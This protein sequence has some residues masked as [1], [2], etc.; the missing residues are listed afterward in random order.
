MT[1][2]LV[3]EIKNSY[4]AP[5]KSLH[6]LFALFPP[7]ETAKHP[8]LAISR[9]LVEAQGGR[10]LYATSSLPQAPYTELI[11]SLPAC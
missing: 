11:I 1:Q 7:K 6:E 4:I 3:E 2:Q 9:L 10:L 8:G 5:Q